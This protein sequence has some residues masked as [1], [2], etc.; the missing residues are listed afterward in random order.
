MRASMQLF[1]ERM[2]GDFWPKYGPVTSAEWAVVRLKIGDSNNRAA[3]FHFS[4]RYR[5]HKS[6]TSSHREFL[7]IAR[8]FN[9]GK[10]W[11]KI[12]S[13]SDV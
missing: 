8:R 3:V 9:A 1:S 13:R 10:D 12:A 4:V 2:P 6:G 5:F 11:R 7:K